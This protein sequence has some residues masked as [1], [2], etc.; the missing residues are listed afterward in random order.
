MRLWRMTTGELEL[1]R[2]KLFILLYAKGI[3]RRPL[4]NFYSSFKDYRDFDRI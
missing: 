3:P 4:F 2:L 1:N